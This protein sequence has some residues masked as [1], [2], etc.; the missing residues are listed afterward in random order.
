MCVCAL[1][2]AVSAEVDE[3]QESKMNT[4]CNRI[5]P[6]RRHVICGLWQSKQVP[7]DF[8]FIH[9]SGLSAETA[10]ASEVMVHVALSFFG[11]L[12]TVISGLVAP[13]SAR[14]QLVA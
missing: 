6:S 12:S 1:A 4:S 13:E 10:M 11:A 7:F 14:T 2:T 5:R 3:D 8:P 9:I